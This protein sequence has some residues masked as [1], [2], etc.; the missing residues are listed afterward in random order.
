VLAVMGARRG[1]RGVGGKRRAGGVR[2]GA[3]IFTPRT[4]ITVQTAHHCELSSFWHGLQIQH[5][6]GAEAAEASAASGARAEAAESRR[7]L[8]EARGALAVAEG[9]EGEVDA[10][11]ERARE[12]QQQ[13]EVI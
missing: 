10:A 5:A 13:H 2:G 12:L 8:A 3:A 1:D 7:L 11:K 6:R 4:P 9:L